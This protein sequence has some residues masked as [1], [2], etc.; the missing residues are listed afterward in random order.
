MRQIHTIVAQSGV[1]GSQYYFIDKKFYFSYNLVE[2]LTFDEPHYARL[3]YFGGSNKQS[4][5]VFADFLQRQNV[6]GHLEP[7]LGC[8]SVA[9][10]SSWVPLASNHI[11]A[12]GYLQITTSD[13]KAIAGGYYFTIVI[14]IAPKSWI[15]GAQK[16]TGL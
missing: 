8:S 13:R 12:I 2:A 6:N 16:Q 7:Y 14:E 10:T 1:E 3:L 15:Y 5:F 9:A 11:P 4:L